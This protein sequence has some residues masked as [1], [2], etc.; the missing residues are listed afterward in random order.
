MPPSANLSESAA[1]SSETL[2]PPAVDGPPRI[3]IWVDPA[4]PW[5]WQ[6]A[7]WLIDLRDQGVLSI[8][9][10]IFSLEIN[11]S[12]PGLPFWEAAKL[13]GEA[14]VAL[15][16]AHREGGDADFERYYVA[17]GRLR[18]DQRQELSQELVRKA[19]VDADRHGLVERGLAQP[20][21]PQAIVAEY[22]L[23]RASD[24]FGVPMLQLLP[25]GSPIYGPILP[26][27]PRGDEA[28]AWW[29]PVLFALEHPEM[30]ELKRWPRDR[31]PGQ[32]A[33]TGDPTPTS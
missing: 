21:L 18:H 3:R 26:L 15:A 4:C 20:E 25:S 16:Q 11:S 10:R 32:P 7:L 24:V 33:P 8:E 22:E 13:N 12:E 30:Y 2:G 29:L 23:A 31:R 1:S 28:L 19:A 14:H 9:W 27:A 6:T 17:L 5:A